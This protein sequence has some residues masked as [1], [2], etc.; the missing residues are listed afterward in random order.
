MLSRSDAISACAMSCKAA[1]GG[2]TIACAFTRN[3]PTARAAPK[4]GRSGMIALW[5]T[6]S[7]CRTISLAV[8]GAIEPSLRRAE[9][10]RVSRKRPDSLD[11]YELV[12][13]AQS[14]IDS[15]MPDRAA[16]ALPLLMRALATDP[17]YALAH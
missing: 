4:S 14:D 13:R 9:I 6:Y 2:A 10:E 5:A 16:D 15:G 8:V 11:A 17:G 3:S 12:L 1:C 7:R